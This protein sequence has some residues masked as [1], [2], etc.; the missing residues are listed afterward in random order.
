M[1]V[2]KIFEDYA[3][4]ISISLGVQEIARTAAFYEKTLGVKL[5]YSLSEHRESLHSVISSG[6]QFAI[7]KA[8]RPEERGLMLH[9]AVGDLE[10]FK[11]NATG[12]GGKVVADNIPLTIAEKVYSEF[13]AQHKGLKTTNK[14]GTL[15]IIKDPEGHSFAAIQLEEWARYLFAPGNITMV[16]NDNQHEG[17]KLGERLKTLLKK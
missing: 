17:I 4:L 14:M 11:K 6:V 9:F 10:K 3:Q 12:A 1:S 2:G 7:D 8:Q 16:E 13:A 5:A 15:A